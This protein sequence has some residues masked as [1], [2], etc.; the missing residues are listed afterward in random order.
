VNDAADYTP[1]FDYA[2]PTLVDDHVLSWLGS[3]DFRLYDPV[4]WMQG[5][6][7]V[8]ENVNGLMG[9][10]GVFV[11]RW[12]EY[13]DVFADA[14]LAGKPQDVEGLRAV[15][16][17]VEFGVPVARQV[18]LL[19]SGGIDQGEEADVDFKQ[20]WRNYGVFGGV[21][22]GPLPFLD[23]SAEYLRTVTHYRPDLEYRLLDDY[24]E[25][26]DPLRGEDAPRRMREGHND[27]L[28]L[29]ARLKF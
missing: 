26:R 12:L 21:M 10:Q 16:G 27:S 9:R 7:W 25:D 15:G 22:W 6:V 13:Q 17:W 5:Q 8:G 29:N 11:D 23:V 19:A 1:G 14:S 28:S 20:V 24:R 2:R 3:F 4:G 18:T